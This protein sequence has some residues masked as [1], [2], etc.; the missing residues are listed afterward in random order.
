MKK[1]I[2]YRHIH[3]IVA[4][5]T[6]FYFWTRFWRFS[7]GFICPLFDFDTFSDIGIYTILAMSFI[8]ALVLGIINIRLKWLYPT[9]VSTFIWLFPAF[10]FVQL[11]SPTD[12]YTFMYYMLYSFFII[13]LGQQIL[14]S[15]GLVIGS[16]IRK[17]RTKKRME[18]LVI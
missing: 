3:I 18:S 2:K 16:L 13:F 7:S 5:S 17:F 10:M 9:Y 11:N 12:T 1:L 8:T 15:L 6:V 14:A 4:V